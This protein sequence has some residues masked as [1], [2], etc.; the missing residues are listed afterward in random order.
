MKRIIWLSRHSM[1]DIQKKDL[2]AFLRQDDLEVTE[3]NATFPAR[4]EEARDIIRDILLRNPDAHVAGVF[5][6]HIAGAIARKFQNCDAPGIVDRDWLAIRTNGQ[7]V[8]VPAS[9]PASAKEGEVRGGG[10]A[11]SHWEAL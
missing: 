3:Q 1:S 9:L 11:H 7:R 4:S 8:F 6:A 5:P 10:F 2:T